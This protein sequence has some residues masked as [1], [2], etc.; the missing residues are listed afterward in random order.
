MLLSHLEPGAGEAKPSIQ[1]LREPLTRRELELLKLIEEGCTNQDIADRLVISIPTVK[2][3]ISNI[4]L[5]LGAKNRTQAI[6]LSKA[7]NLFD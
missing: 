5:K 3:H 7:L 6:S 4:Y 2:R 1:L